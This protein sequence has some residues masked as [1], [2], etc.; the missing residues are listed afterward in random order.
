MDS[1]RYYIWSRFFFSLLFLD[2]IENTVCNIVHRLWYQCNV[3]PCNTHF[4]FVF[5]KQSFIKDIEDDNKIW[6]EKLHFIELNRIYY[7]EKSNYTNQD[8]FIEWLLFLMRCIV[9]WKVIQMNMSYVSKWM[10]TNYTN[11]CFRWFCCRSKHFFSYFEQSI[12]KLCPIL[13]EQER[14]GD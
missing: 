1:I 2:I 5:V 3:Y 7:I 8:C 6:L 14:K 11:N 10:N 4:F 13:H 9:A 12:F